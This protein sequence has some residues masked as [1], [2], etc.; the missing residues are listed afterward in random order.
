M[1]TKQRA[2]WKLR[3]K[4]INWLIKTLM[5]FTR[6]RIRETRGGVPQVFFSDTEVIIQIP[7]YGNEI[8]RLKERVTN[9]GG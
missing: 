1:E 2:G 6:M 8:E 9:L 3:L 4:M 5:P 7:D